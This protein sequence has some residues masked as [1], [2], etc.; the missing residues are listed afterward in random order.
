MIKYTGNKTKEMV[1]YYTHYKRKSW[2]RSRRRQSNI[3][4]K[5]MLCGLWR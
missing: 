2:Q 5:Y 4:K 1:C 3:K